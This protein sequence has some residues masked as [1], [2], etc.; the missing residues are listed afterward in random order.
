MP[1]ER[2]VDCQCLLNSDPPDTTNV[3][4]IRNRAAAKMP[5]RVENVAR[6]LG[7]QPK[8]VLIRDQRVRWASCGP[9]GTL[10]FNWRIVMAKPGLI[11]YVV[12]H[13]LAHLRFRPHS[14]DYWAVVSQVVRDY[15][16]RRAELAEAGSSL[17][18]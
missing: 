4:T 16:L 12:A 17:D 8:S 9:D 5:A 13:E 3:M 18:L 10:R 11:D 15:R 1:I 6:L 2:F 14:S 7:V